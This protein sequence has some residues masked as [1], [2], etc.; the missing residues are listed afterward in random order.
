[1][2]KKKFLKKFY[3]L[4]LGSNDG[5]FLK[6][7]KKKGFGFEPSKS[8]HDVSKRGIQSIN[9][10]FNLKNIE[11]F[12]KRIFLMLYLELTFFAIFQIKKIYYAMDKVLEEDGNYF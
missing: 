1:M 8:V 2:D 10:F 12:R 5:T 4:E 3:L 7:S 9:K 11:Q 6:I